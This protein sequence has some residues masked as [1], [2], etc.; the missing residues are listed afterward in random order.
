VLLSAFALLELGTLFHHFCLPL[1]QEA[2]LDILA[3]GPHRQVLYVVALSLLQH[4]EVLID[5]CET[6]FSDDFDN[7]TVL[8]Q[9]RTYMAL[10]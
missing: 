2:L 6:H 1:G 8:S 7:R 9:G 3:V 5:K 4:L 10:L